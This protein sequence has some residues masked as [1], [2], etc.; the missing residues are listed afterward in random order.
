MNLA[1]ITFI[2]GV[3]LITSVLASKIM[4]RFGVPTL[5]LFLALG[6]FLGSEGFG[7]IAF[8]DYGFAGIIAQIAL[9]FI[10]FSGGFDT[11]WKR[12]DKGLPLAI[13]LSSLGTIFTAL[14][15][16]I[17]SYFILNV[18]LLVGFLLGSI[19]A[20]TDAASVFSILRSKQLNL[21]NNLASTLEIESGSNDPFAYLLTI[22]FLAL[23]QGSGA[24]IFGLIFLQL[25]VGAMVGFGV[26]FS[27]VFLINRI[28]LL[29]DGLYM[30][31]AV[32]VMA[33][34][35]GLATLLFGNGYLAVYLTGLIM[36]NKP[37]THKISLVRFFDGLTW[38]MQI[39]L[40]FTLGLLVFPSQVLAVIWE[41]LAIALFL[42]F[43]ARPIAVFF[44]M[45]W[46]K[47]P[48]K[49]IIL[50]SWVG[51]RGAA[52]IVFAIF[53][54]TSNLPND[55]GFYLFN[56]VFFVAVFSV[57]LQ[58]TTMSWLAK[59]LGL[60]DVNTNVLTTFSDYRGDTYAE[61]L[62]FDVQPQ[63]PLVGKMIREIEIPAHL[64]IV[65]IKRKQSVVTPKANTTINAHDILLLASDDK[66][67]LLAFAKGKKINLK[68]TQ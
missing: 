14:L 7:G 31:I 63:S 32:S 15:V 37:L 30:V 52:S 48:I 38:L 46:F 56:I 19:I 59:R 44:I 35:F 1:L 39:L 67:E 6:I 33:L 49:E 36:A 58:G 10:I 27:S 64:L 25:V 57:L 24:N 66:Q 13:S 20:S 29:I 4:Y 51:F 41:G 40:F 26:G 11:A 42:S 2:V 55:L 23:I 22:F 50:M 54:I 43:V 5:I 21:K 16:G 3:V 68:E 61:L 53:V 47:R 17:F 9:I 8:S 34:S 62:H 65:M 12:G 18:D 28:N 60:T 45:S